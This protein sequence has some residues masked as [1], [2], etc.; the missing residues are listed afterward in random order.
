MQYLEKGEFCSSQ[1]RP[2][3]PNILYILA[4]PTFSRTYTINTYFDILCLPSVALMN[5]CPESLSI[6]TV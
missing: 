4:P 3:P 5:P 6:L 2:T 1:I